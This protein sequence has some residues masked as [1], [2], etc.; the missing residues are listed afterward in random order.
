MAANPENGEEPLLS[1]YSVRQAIARHFDV[2]DMIHEQMQIQKEQSRRLG[3][4]VI[5]S[6]LK[7]AE[8]NKDMALLTGILEALEESEDN[9]IDFLVEYLRTSVPDLEDSVLDA[10]EEGAES[11]QGEKQI[12]DEVETEEKGEIDV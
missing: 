5:N 11:A 4:K 3:L 1:Q 7:V 10:A 12:Q 6:I 9:A 2:D 8:D